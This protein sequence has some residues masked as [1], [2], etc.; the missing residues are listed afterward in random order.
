MSPSVSNGRNVLWPPLAYAQWQPTCK[1]LH[2]LTQIA[3]KVR[4]ALTPWVNHSW[5]VPFYVSPRGLTTGAISYGADCFELTFDFLHHRLII[6]ASDGTQKILPL[7]AGSIA[8]FYEAFFKV[9]GDLGIEVKIS[10]LPNEVPDATPFAADVEARPYDEEAVLRF[11][12]I[13]RQSSR[14]LQLFRTRFV[15]K[16]SPV[17]F[18]WGSFDLAVTR[19]SGR[20]APAH[21]GGIPNLPDAVTREAYSHEVSSAGFWPGGPGLEYPVFYSYAYPAP[22]GFAEA[23]VSPPEAFYS[24]EFGEFV[25]PYE[26]MRTASDPE[27]ALLEFLQSTYEAAASLARW[28]RK[29]LERPQGELGRPPSG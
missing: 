5:H 3:G 19:F 14:V 23:K 25:L 17:H 6:D 11:W 8:R 16:N 20:P 13:L 22:D 2:L 1:H 18:F 29:A 7:G 10:P 4:L 28:D 26:A 12:Q 24:R 9:L 21:P 15:G 27:S